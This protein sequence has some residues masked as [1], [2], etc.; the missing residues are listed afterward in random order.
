MFYQANINNPV[1]INLS[2]QA[3]DIRNYMREMEIQG[4][5]WSDEDFVYYLYIESLLEEIEVEL[6]IMQVNEIF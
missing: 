5:I 4:D 1:Y 6:H 2:N 3:H